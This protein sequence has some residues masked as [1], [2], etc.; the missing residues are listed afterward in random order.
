MSK[1]RMTV[2]KGLLGLIAGGFM[3]FNVQA[4]DS[5][6]H[7]PAAF[8]DF[9]LDDNGFISEEEFNTVR[10]QRMAAKTA[11]GKQMRGAATAPAFTDIDSDGDGQL[12]PEELSAA[13]QAHRGKNHANAYGQGYGQGQGHGHGH[14]KKMANGGCGEG[15]GKGMKGD[16]PTFSDFDLNGDGKIVE[17]E[18]NQGHAKRMSEMA[19]EGRQMRH[20]GD[21]PGFSAV[22]SNG[23]GEVSAEEFAAHQA[24]HH[25]Q[26]HQCKNM[27][28]QQQP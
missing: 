25:H 21:A 1:L 7:G 18:F 26:M 4:A 15:K 20:V 9:D 23:N 6:P 11:E 8:S 2:A 17:T 14:G 3:A 16:M 24:E 22:D 10:G 5:P 13:Q 28:E 12:N 27:T 19:A